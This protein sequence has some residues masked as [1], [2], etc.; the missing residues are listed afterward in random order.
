MSLAARLAWDDMVLPFQLDRSAIRGRVVRLEGVLDRILRQ[1][2][3]PTPVDNLVAEAVLLTALIGQAIKLRWRLSVQVRGDG[4]I[5]LIATDYF[6]P[7]VDGEP[8][9]LR[10]YAQFDADRVEND[11]NAFLQLGRGFFALTIDQGRDMTPYQGITPLAGG[12]LSACAETYFAHSEQLPTRFSLHASRSGSAEGARWRGGGVMLQQLPKSGPV[13]KAPSQ[14]NDGLLSAQDLLHGAEAEDWQRSTLLLATAKPEE[15]LGPEVQPTDLLL[16]LFHEE[17]PRVFSTQPL[18]FGCSC[19]EEKLRAVLSVYSKEDLAE[20]AT[21]EGL[22][23]ADCQFCGAR[24][25]FDPETLV[26]E[27]RLEP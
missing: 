13:A 17:G 18:S 2:R 7:K 5:R 22:V 4:P 19:S 26:S 10:G 16:R 1:H 21:P 6:A 14:A 11:L 23:V 9:L 15:L 3:Y 20:M 8:A 12:S 24:Y 27:R 25:V